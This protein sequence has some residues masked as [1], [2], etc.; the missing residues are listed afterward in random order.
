MHLPPVE[1]LLLLL[2]LAIPLMLLRL[3]PWLLLLQS[4]LQLKQLLLLCFLLLLQQLLP[5]LQGVIM[6]LCS[7]GID[8]DKVCS[9]EGPCWLCVV[10]CRCVRAHKPSGSAEEPP[11]PLP[12][13]AAQC[14]VLL[15]SHHSHQAATHPA[16]CHLPLHR[17]RRQCP[18]LS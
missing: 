9:S 3:Q 13:Q 6:L 15:C 18:A 12:Q 2:C 17:W 8:G 4:L 1:L 14:N 11:P 5:L 7:A 10:V 16:A